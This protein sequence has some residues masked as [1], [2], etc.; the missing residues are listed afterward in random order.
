VPEN[1][2]EE[3]H[4]GQGNGIEDTQKEVPCPRNK[5]KENY[6]GK[7]THQCKKRK[8]FKEMAT[9]A[10]TEDDLEKIGDQVKEV[11]NKSFQRALQKQEEIH[12]YMHEQIAS[13]HQLLE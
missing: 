2:P 7:S 8:S 6:N 4:D 1:N 11:T 12:T 9:Q 10:L 13:L 3:E 5:R